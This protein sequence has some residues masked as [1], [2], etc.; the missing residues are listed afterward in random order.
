MKQDMILQTRDLHKWFP[1]SKGLPGGL[2]PH[3]IKALNGV[4]IDVLRG[5]TLGVVGESGCGK[6]TFGRTVIRLQE[7]TSGQIFFDGRDITHCGQRELQPIRR[8]MQMIFQ[9]PYASLD[10]RMRIG[11]C[12]GE[13]LDIQKP[14]WSRVQRQEA[15]VELLEKCGLSRLDYEKY[16]HEFSGGQRQRIG[17]ARALALQ[18]RLLL[19]DEPV[20]ALDV[21]IQ[22]HLINLM[23]ALQQEHALTLL[24]IS[25]DLSVIS[26][27]ADRVAV[28]YLGKI[29]ELATRDELF[30]HALHPYTQA[31]LAS[32]PVIGQHD[33]I[34]PP[35]LEG[36]LPSL[37]DPP[38]TC[39]LYN[40]C[41]HRQPRC[42]ESVP[43]LNEVSPGHFCSCHLV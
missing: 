21:S 1:L 22:A 39:P 13:P 10:P 2:R 40:R 42:R 11:E 14:E 37:I 28:M 29:V 16:P 7:P 19:C 3:Y 20:S 23:M 27:V 41:P 31:L 35:L 33:G 5:E 8:E 17:I 34:R 15:V 36:E 18:P 6:T 43:Q 4:S 38:D 26:H 30:S 25:H 12:I 24:F 9:D 32:V